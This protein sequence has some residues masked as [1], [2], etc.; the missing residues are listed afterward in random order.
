MVMKGLG[1]SQTKKLAFEEE[2]WRLSGCKEKTRTRGSNVMPQRATRRELIEI[3][4]F[5]SSE[6]NIDEDPIVEPVAEPVAEPEVEQEEHQVAKKPV[7]PVH[8]RVIIESAQLEKVLEQLPCPECGGKL[9]SCIVESMNYLHC[10]FATSVGVWSA[11]QRNA[12][13][14]ST[15]NN[16]PQLPFTAI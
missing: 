1:R 3:I 12:S 16:H 7:K 15:Q 10:C 4:N 2:D 14:S 13:T 5:L 11:V 8:K 9:A 6:D